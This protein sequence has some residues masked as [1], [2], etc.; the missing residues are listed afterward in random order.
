VITVRLP[1]LAER[2]PDI[3]LLAEHFLAR[4]CAD[5]GLA[6][7]RLTPDARAAL[8][9]YGW[10]GNIRELVNV[11]ERV[12]LLTDTS[13]VTAA[14]L[15]LPTRS[16]TE[17]TEPEPGSRPQSFRDT[18]GTVERAQL[19]EVLNDTQWN[20]VRAAA[21]L[22]I[23]R[24]TLRYRIEKLGLQRSG[25]PPAH[26]GP[27]GPRSVPE[28]TPPPRAGP[29][30]GAPS[31][32]RRQL[33]FLR[34]TLVPPPDG[35]V[36]LEHTRA[37]EVLAAKAESFGG[38]VEGL[39]P[40]SVVAA[41]GLVDYRPEYQHGWGNKP[42]YT[43]LRLD[44][45]PPESV[46][47]LLNT[48][49]GEDPELLRLKALLVERSEGN[50]FFLEEIVQ[51]LLETGALVGEQGAHQLA[52]PIDT[53]EVPATVQAVLA[54]RID[55]LSPADKA[56]LQTASVVGKDVPL[57]LL[58][59]IAELGEDELHAAIG[60]FQAAE[61]LYEA[62]IFPD[63]EYTFKHALTHDVTYGTLLQER[64][65]ALHARIVQTIEAL[66]PDRLAEHVDRLA[67][68]AF[69]GE[70]WEKAV[71]YLRQAGVSAE[72]R[73][74]HRAA[75]AW[76]EQALSALHEMPAT[77]ETQEQSID[78]R[79]ALRGST[80]FAGELGKLYPSLREAESLAQTLGDQHRLG[81]VWTS[82]SQYFLVSGDSSQARTY[83]QKA[84]LIGAAFGDVELTA[85]AHY[86]LG[87]A[88][89]T[90]GDLQGAENF[91][92]KA[93][94]DLQGAKD[95][96]RKAVQLLGQEKMVQ[97]VARLSATSRWSLAVSL[98]RRAWSL[99]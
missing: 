18:M 83:A 9:A 53:V 94:G 1:P 2:G 73:S 74:A 87:W 58:Q 51:T 33:A 31:W 22:R 30:R 37:L 46:Q 41:F 23:P 27:P 98:A 77:R 81:W 20:I 24:G 62:G 69:R 39:G 7:R 50:P 84:E 5:Y 21:R 76:F 59:A 29:F 52:R 36:G 71:A 16:E 88:C 72:A 54:A 25:A 43:Q 14:V 65:R 6:G 55:R 15:G 64:R 95:S 13:V 28:P 97:L 61:F 26:A 56:L 63:L 78:V 47:A 96:L 19:L 90:A 82:M 60:R 99:R 49:L 89:H 10:P 45:L 38:R 32:E 91:I 48:L 68:H 66:Y 67:H 85:M 11:M 92:R 42:A 70:V 75:V 86:Y 79:I 44:P 40:L 35:D 8:C 80:W 3:L 57:G 17:T 34:A 4:A 93:I 12:A